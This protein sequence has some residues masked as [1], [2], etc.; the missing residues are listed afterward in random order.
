MEPRFVD[1]LPP[2]RKIKTHT[3]RVLARDLQDRPG[4]WAEIRSYAG[5]RR[6]AAY[7]YAHNCR[8]G[9]NKSLSPASG[10]EVEAR[11]THAGTVSVFARYVGGGR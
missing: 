3:L 9:K 5:K 6:N 11:A 2:R 8:T 1:E 7:V 10:F 4:E